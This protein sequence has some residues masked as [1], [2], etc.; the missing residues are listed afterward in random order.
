MGTTGAAC[1]MLGMNS[2]GDNADTSPATSYPKVSNPRQLPSPLSNEA[3]LTSD[4]Q[5]H[6]VPSEGTVESQ[7]VNG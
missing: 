3:I 7:G 6:E 5:M 4:T 1:R 2:I